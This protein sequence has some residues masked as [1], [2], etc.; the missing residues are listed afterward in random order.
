MSH[1]QSRTVQNPLGQWMNVYGPKTKK[2]GQPLPAIYP[3]EIEGQTWPTAAQAGAAADQ[4]SQNNSVPGLRQTEPQTNP[5][6]M[7]LRLLMPR[8]PGR[9]QDPNQP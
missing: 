5:F 4:R 7:I 1:E 2:A 3:W 9:G 8:L 6:E